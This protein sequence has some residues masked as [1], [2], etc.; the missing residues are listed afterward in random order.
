M[1][2][3]AGCVDR[4][5]HVALVPA[6][7][8][9]MVD[10]TALDPGRLDRG[11]L[12]RDRRRRRSNWTDELSFGSN[13]VRIRRMSPSSIDGRRSSL[14]PTARARPYPTALRRGRL[15][16]TS[17]SMRSAPSC[18]KCS[19]EPASEPTDQ[20]GIDGTQPDSINSFNTSARPAV[21]MLASTLPGVSSPRSNSC[22]AASNLVRSGA[23]RSKATTKG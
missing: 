3:G 13:A 11:R 7:H 9:S 14:L 19:A 2:W 8:S 5:R 17:M 1:P 6:R 21:F 15:D 20:A 12:D 16:S 10:A 22:H 23:G 4:R 18:A